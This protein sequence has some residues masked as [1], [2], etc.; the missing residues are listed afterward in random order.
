[1]PAPEVF[2]AYIAAKTSRIHLGSAIFNTTPP[3][4]HPARVAERVA[5]IDHLSEGRFE[6]GS[7]R[8]SSTTEV[9]GYGIPSLEIT[10]DMWDETIVEFVK[11][12]RERS[13]SH[14]GTFF[15]MPPR[16]V[17]P[18]PYTNPHPPMWVACGS[19]STLAKA[20]RLGLGGLC[21]TIGAPAMIAPLVQAYKDNIVAPEPVGDYVNDNVACVTTFLCME[22][23]DEAFRIASDIH[24]A[25]YQSLVF[26]WLDNIPKPPGLPEWPAMLPEPTPEAIEEGTRTG[27]FA[28][29][30]P[31]DCANAVQSYADIGCDQLIFSPLTTTMTME[32][33][34]G[35]VELFGRDVMPKF[36]RDPVHS[37]TRQRD[38]QLSPTASPAP[39][40]SP[41][42]AIHA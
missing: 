36:D 33:A 5:M 34:V 20:G 15:S 1:M 9:F 22:D 16:N 14:D 39:A 28:I 13:Y 23:R 31:D 35:S 17:L 4:N 21:F 3:V 26:H 42:G 10:S 30:D 27:M 25:Y 38:A 8:G 6:F 7:G 37:T 2:L 32:Q 29:G 11:M 24:I 19:P 12:W 40:S 18:K 41:G